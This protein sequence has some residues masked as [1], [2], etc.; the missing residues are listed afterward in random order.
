MQF[1]SLTDKGNVRE[2]NEDFCF[3]G[4]IGDYTV[5][6]LA[7]GMGGH[8][9][10][11]TASKI[12]SERIFGFLGKKLSGNLLPGQIM[13][14]LAEALDGANKTIFS[15]SINQEQLRGMGTTIDVCV[16]IK[17]TAYI[18]HIGDSR[19]YKITPEGTI[20]KLT[21]DHSLVEYMIDSGTITREEA[22]HH[23]QKNIIT[24]AL[25]IAP[26][27]DSDVFSTTL[28]EEETLLMCSDGLSNMLSEEEIVTSVCSEK[29]LSDVAR[30]L[31][32]LANKAGGTDNITVVLAKQD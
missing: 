26:D 6:I 15:Q 1:Y 29:S 8:N 20:S 28:S 31:V 9:A 32:E 2:I 10:G 12:A 13:L 18:A 16:I 25:G 27:V 21:K 5:L 3:S 11:E 22:E 30:E 4:Q 14:L 19:V 24:R 23:P 7:D 17:N